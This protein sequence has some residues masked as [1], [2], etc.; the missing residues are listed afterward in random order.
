MTS[1][2]IIDVNEPE[3]QQEVLAYSTQMPVVVD[4]WAE[5]CIPCRTL[6]PILEK[7][8]E[9]A[10]GTFRLAKLNV[11]ENPRLAR[12]YM[13]SSIPAVKVFRGGQVAN[14]FTGAR[15]EAEVREFLLSMSPSASDLAIEKGNS[16]YL[17]QQWD[18]AAQAYRECLQ[19]SPD[20]GEALLGLAKTELAAGNQSTALAI[21][22]EF[23][24]SKQ[25]AIAERLQPLA[26]AIADIEINQGDVADQEPLESVYQNSLNLVGRGNIPAAID[27]LLHVAR[28][29]KNYRDG[30]ARQALLGMLEMLEQDSDA[31]RDFRQE[32]ASI[33]F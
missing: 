19:A 14:E 5:W 10:Q 33:L 1:E 13:I 4:F 12:H 20:K 30:E 27:G 17:D 15:S 24:A 11:D 28:E 3:F 18:A 16:L 23:P 8:T 21:L 25:Y 2:Y 31:V 7:L 26:Q 22:R 6:G 9:E 29:D 32:L